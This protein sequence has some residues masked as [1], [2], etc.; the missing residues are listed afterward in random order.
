M[1]LDIAKIRA[2]LDNVKNNGKAG[3]SF[4]RPK[5][6][7]QAIRI[8]PTQDGVLYTTSGKQVYSSHGAD[9][10]ES[11]AA[12]YGAGGSFGVRWDETD[13]V[14]DDPS[15][16]GPQAVEISDDAV[17]SYIQPWGTAIGDGDPVESA[18]PDLE[19]H[20]PEG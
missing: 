11:D 10:R 3:G 13:P 16:Q 2:R 15:G 19:K 17:L 6:G 14:I 20:N 5:D 9:W 7:T 4:W 12:L 1:A 8:V 18:D